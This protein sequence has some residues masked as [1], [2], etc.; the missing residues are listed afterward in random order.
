MLAPLPPRTGPYT[1]VT[2]AG[3]LRAQ[4]SNRTVLEAFT[5]LAQPTL[6]VRPY[7]G[8]GN[9]PHFN[10]DL[11]SDEDRPATI[12]DWRSEVARA[13][14]MVISSPEYAH[15]VPGSLKNALD[16]LVSGPEFPALP[17]A[18]INTSPHST[19]AQAALAETIRTMSADLIPPGIWLVPLAGR[20]PGVSEVL[21]DPALTQALQA[22]IAAIARTIE[23]ARAEG[24]RLVS[25]A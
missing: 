12:R 16:W 1:V 3:S 20:R 21:R 7:H 22:L 19:H 14:A 24:R 5:Q 2:L 23:R 6:R 11:D 8:I 15:G 10:P 17:V 18:L 9:L 13:D 25:Q 4:S